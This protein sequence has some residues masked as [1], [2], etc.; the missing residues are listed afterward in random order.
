MPTSKAQTSLLS[1]LWQV[2]LLFALWKVKWLN[3]HHEKFQNSCKSLDSGFNSAWLK[4]LKTFFSWHNL[5]NKEPFQILQPLQTIDDTTE[6][7]YNI[8]AEA[9]G[10]VVSARDFVSLRRAAQREGRY[11]SIATGCT[12]PDMPAQKKYV[13]WVKRDS[14]LPLP[15]DSRLSCPD[16]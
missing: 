8:A 3:L 1:I 9:A 15:K 11:L 7:T 6:V 14:P 5:Y 16:I 4:T 13:R 12:H 2:S 10:G